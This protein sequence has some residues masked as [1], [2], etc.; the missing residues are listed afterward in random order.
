MN[1]LDLM[2][3]IGVD[4]KASKEIDGI[5]NGITSKLSTAAKVGGAALAAIAAATVAVVSAFKDAANAVAEYGDNVDKM[6]QKMGMSASSFQE[7]DSVMRHCGTSMDTMKASMK[8]L[9]NAAETDSEAFDRLGISQ[10]QIANMSQ[11]ELFAAT[12]Q[13]LQNVESTTERTYLAGKLLGRG[14]T[15]LGPLLN[16]TAEETQAMRDRVHELGGVMSDEAVKASAAYKDSMQDLNTAMMGVK[17]RIMAEFLPGI[18]TVMDGLQEVFIGNSRKGIELVNRGVADALTALQEQLP[19]IIDI[20]VN[21]LGALANAIITNFPKI[22]SAVMQGIAEII[23]KV[24]ENTDG[25]IE[26]AIEFIGGMLTAFLESAPQIIESIVT[27]VINLI[28]SVITHA[29]DMLAAGIQFMASLIQAIIDSVGGILSAI[30]TAIQ[31]GVDKVWE[32][33][34]DMFDAGANLIT[35]I[36]DGI[37]SAIGGVVDTIMGGLSGAVEKVKSFLGIASPSKLFKS[38][39]QMT[40]LG[41]AEGIADNAKKAEEAMVAAAQDVYDAASGSVELGINAGL[42]PAY[43]M[44]GYGDTY[45]ITMNVTAD[46]ETTLERLLSEVRRAAAFN[47]R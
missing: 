38:F 2:V 36:I 8:T 5:G 47:G 29:P 33:F 30:G 44:A 45:N 12:I 31:S 43:A 6:S 10:E 1:L 24:S 42:Q 25:M 15:E 18:T 39:G 13:G 9:A 37:K 46:S 19:K 34:G 21:I 41:M 40:M 14:A 17:N 20:T 28:G 26:A 3:K 23:N 16:M 27:L 4:D 35:G 11:E 32:F 22:L 7:W